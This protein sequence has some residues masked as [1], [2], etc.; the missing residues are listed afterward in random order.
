L[1]QGTAPGRQS[2]TQDQGKGIVHGSKLVSVEAAGGTPEAL[3]IDDGGLL[4]K[5]ARLGSVKLDRRTKRG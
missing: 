2:E 4:D 3:G 5:D 1:D